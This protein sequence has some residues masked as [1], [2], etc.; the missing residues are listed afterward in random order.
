MPGIQKFIHNL[1]GSEFYR[2]IFSLF[3]GIFSA[4]LIP[5]F[6][7]ILLAR[8]YNPDNFGD[9]VLFLSI[10]SLI[11]IFSNGGYEGAF[12]LAE[13]KWQ[14]SRL[15][16]FSL[17]NNLIINV[18]LFTGLLIFI[19]FFNRKHNCQQLLLLLIPWY[20][21]SFGGLQI[22]RNILI[23]NKLF[24][25]LAVLEI[26]RTVSTG[27]LQSLFFVLPDTGLML[28]MVI[29][30]FV[31]F[32]WFVFQLQETNL[33]VPLK[34]S[35]CELAL[36]KR[37]RNFPL[38]SLPAEFFN[39][40]SNQLPVFMI[41]PFFG[42]TQLGLYSF[43]HRYLN[44]PVQLTSIS[45]GSV[46]IQKARSLK[47]LPAELSEITFGLFQKQVWLAVLP[48]TVLALWGQPIFSFIFGN[49]WAYSGQLA[50]ILSPWLFAVFIS[51][52]LSTILIAMEKQKI[53]MIFNIMLLIF[54]ILALLIG[55]L[56]LKNLTLTVTFFS[57]TGFLFFTFLGIYALILARVDLRKAML[58]LVK[59]VCVCGIP[60]LLLYL[61]L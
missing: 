6:F 36:A 59:T 28:G 49:E 53:S 55:G 13:N 2:N 56:I 60:L 25:K 42:L 58:V 38:F 30:Q 4:R 20:A 54:R 22:I 10:S 32:F 26:V 27:I 41:K 12:I 47:N 57:L 31:T 19:V 8:I 23:S 46:Y 52:P 1:T 24:K 37:F 17:R 33:S 14:K 34:Y 39:Y 5:L 50:Q 44:I 35:K 9:F 15:F 18:I 61:W 29:A 16:R 7:A 21:F 48:F 40:L 11:A 43:S 3:T 45:I 51:S